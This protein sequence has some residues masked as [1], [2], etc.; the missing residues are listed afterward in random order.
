MKKLNIFLLGLVIVVTACEDPIDVELAE[1]PP[2]L[3]VD[4]WLNNMTDQDQIII[5]SRSQNYLQNTFTERVSNA[6]VELTNISQGKTYAFTEEESGSYHY[7]DV[8]NPI[9]AVGDTF[10]LS[11]K[12]ESDEYTSTTVMNR[13]PPIDSIRQ[14][15]RENE[16]FGDDG[17]YCELMSRDFI[18]LGDTYWIKTWKND[19]YLNR[20]AEIN[21]AY[22]AGFDGGSMV[23]G[24]IFITPIREAINPLT[25]DLLFEPWEVQDT[26][27]VEVHSM[28]IPTFNYMETLRDQL[29]NSL[30][31]IF[32]E[33][34]YN[35][36]GNIEHV[37]GDDEVLGAF[38]VA[39]VSSVQ[40]II[41]E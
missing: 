14:E 5:L 9:G 2:Q 11:I 26:I 1:A 10:T 16:L 38:N 34:L 28:S 3:V 40:H 19:Q 12:V 18:G 15:Y 25:D 20:P 41:V 24:F 39:A 29:I 33:P 37:N 23:D 30:N 27:Y 21:I 7:Q 31:G 6:V 36:V 13:V 35:T 32:A 4:A 8:A 17:Y 22:D